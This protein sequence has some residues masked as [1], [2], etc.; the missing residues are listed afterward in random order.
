MEKPRMV[1]FDVTALY[2]SLPHTLIIDKLQSFLKSAGIQD[3]TITLIIRLTSLCL[4]ISTFTFNH[5]HYKQIRGTPMGSPLSSIVA[6]VVMVSLDQWINQTHSSDIHYWRRYVD[7]LFCIIKPNKLQPIL[8]TLHSFHADIKF[9][10]ETETNLVLPFLDILIIRT[11]HKLH[12]TVYY[13]KNI[14]PLYTHFSSNSPVAYKINTVYIHI[15][16]YLYSKP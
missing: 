6:E 16:H 10:Y 11:P 7:D 15:A 5:Q 12:T 1:S 3:Q 13:K 9:T 2:L 4:S 8:N 14:P